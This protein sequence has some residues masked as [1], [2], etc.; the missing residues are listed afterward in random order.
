MK[1]SV[2]LILFL[3]PCL[4]CAAQQPD[5]SQNPPTVPTHQE[6][7]VVTGTYQPINLEDLNRNV[8]SIDFEQSRDLFSGWTDGLRLDPSIDLRQRAPGIQEDLSIRGSSFGQTL[9]LVNGLRVNDAQT[10]HHNLDLPVPFESIDRI[11]VLHGSGSTMYGSDAVGGAANFITRRPSVTGIRLSAGGGNYGSNEQS[12]SLFYATEPFSE[13]LSFTRDFSSGFMPDRDYRNLAIA[14]QTDLRTA[15]GNTDLLLG[16]SDRPFGADQF[17]GNFNS[18]ERTKGWFLGASQDLGKRTQFAFGYRRHTDEFILLRDNPSVYENNHI[19]ESY[20]SAIRRHDPLNDSLS[21]FYGAEVYRDVIDS[22]NL[23]YHVRNQLAL[24][25]NLDYRSSSRF[26]FSAGAREEI[27][28]GSHYELSPTVSAGY[29]LTNRLRLKASASRAFRL[30]TFTDLY[31]HDPANVGNPNLQPERAWSYEGGLLWV[32][33]QRVSGEFTVFRRM[34]RN[35]IDY[36]RDGNTGPWMAENIE[37]LNFTGFEAVAYIDWTASQRVAI[38]YTGMYGAQQSLNAQQSKYVRDYPV[39]RATVSWLGH[40]PARIEMRTA[41]GV[42]QRYG[43]G[44][45]PLLDASVMRT[46]GHLTPYLRLTNTLNTGYEEIQG[47]RMPGRAL[48][49]GLSIEFH[50]K[51]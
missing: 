12:G 35:G 42:T 2:G 26:S 9:V 6:S 19:T 32:A 48:I 46:F 50:R 1:L 22:N 11:E 34:D 37:R 43:R 5:T 29:R 31:Y 49:A 33:S 27:Y 21:L 40:A 23:G 10:G 28:T 17:Y 14:S 3:L 47:V 20:Q 36:V 18:W 13:Q 41:L 4:P 15:L 16:L 8:Q 38:G 7:I 51:N 30:P 44:A 39:H 24:Y 45:D 25:L